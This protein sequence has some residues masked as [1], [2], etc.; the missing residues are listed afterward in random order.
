MPYY[1]RFQFQRLGGSCRVYQREQD[2][3]ATF[4]G[5]F[6]IQ[7]FVAQPTR[8]DGILDLVLSDHRSI[9]R[10]VEMCEGLGNSDHNKVIISIALENKAKDNNT[11]VPSFNQADFDGIIDTS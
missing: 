10:E 6:F 4:L 7:Q 11:L 1:G 9:V 5:D 3:L 8:R 2:V